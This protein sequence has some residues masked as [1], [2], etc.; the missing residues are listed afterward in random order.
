MDRVLYSCYT[1]AASVYFKFLSVMLFIPKVTHQTSCIFLLL[2]G[3]CE[4]MKK[5]TNSQ[6]TKLIFLCPMSSDHH[7]S[8]TDQKSPFENLK[9]L[10]YLIF[11][12]LVCENNAVDHITIII[13]LCCHFWNFSC[14]NQRLP[15]QPSQMQTHI[16]M[17]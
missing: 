12:Y 17:H 5:V 1:H 6:N 15:W 3:M 13:P 2:C 10:T 4:L 16:P 11:F 14:G 7:Q 9:C 8:I